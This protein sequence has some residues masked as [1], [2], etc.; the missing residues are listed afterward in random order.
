[1]WIFWPV[2][3]SSRIR[4]A[5]EALRLPPT[6]FCSRPALP[7]R[8]TNTKSSIIVPS[9][10]HFQNSSSVPSS[11]FSL[12]GFYSLTQLPFDWISCF[13]TQSL[14]VPFSLIGRSKERVEKLKLI[15]SCS[16]ELSNRKNGRSAESQFFGTQGRCESFFLTYYFPVNGVD[17][18]NSLHILLLPARRWP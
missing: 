6:F 9:Y 15:K 4:R 16:F 10:T 7:Q 2:V 12:S 3:P 17:Q 5:V 18:V 1:M 13:I 14:L 8:R 11:H